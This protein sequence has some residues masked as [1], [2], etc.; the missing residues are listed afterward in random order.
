ME[1]CTSAE[2]GSAI[3]IWTAGTEPSLVWEPGGSFLGRQTDGRRY[4]IRRSFVSGI[5]SRQRIWYCCSILP[6]LSESCGNG[7]HWNG[8]SQRSDGTAGIRSAFPA[9]EYR[10]S[11]AGSARQETG[12]VL[13]DNRSTNGV[14][15]NGGYVRGAQALRDKDVIQILGF[16]LVFCQG[17]IYYK[18]A[19]KGISL[20]VQGLRRLLERKEEKEDS[21]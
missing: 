19:A 12:F 3:R 20:Q 1:D 4:L 11:I 14:L 10:R 17:C 15:V 6:A 9:L 7:S 8:R 21:K 13:Q 2:T 5:L 16:Q 18:S